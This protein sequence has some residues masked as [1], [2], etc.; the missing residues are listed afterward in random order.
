MQITVKIDP[1]SLFSPIL[2]EQLLTHPLRIVSRTKNGHEFANLIHRV[3]ETQKTQQTQTVFLMSNSLE[4]ISN[5]YYGTLANVFN[6]PSDDSLMQL[7]QFEDTPP[8]NNFGEFNIINS[9]H[10]EEASVSFQTYLQE[11]YHL[12]GSD[13]QT[14]VRSLLPIHLIKQAEYRYLKRINKHLTDRLKSRHKS[15]YELLKISIPV[16]EHT[17]KD[18]IIKLELTHHEDAVTIEYNTSTHSI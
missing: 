9:Q 13:L 18:L 11:H 4:T 12:T 1:Q 6:F 10:Y 16:A 3:L 15:T 17:V 14:S 8:T 2:L 5:F 7:N